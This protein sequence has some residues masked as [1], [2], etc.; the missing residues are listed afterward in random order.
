MVTIILNRCR[1]DLVFPRVIT[2]AVMLGV[3]VIFI[4][5][6]SLTLGKNSLVAVYLY[7]TNSVTTVSH[8]SERATKS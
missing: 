1:Y 2:I 3:K 7:C 4:F 5:S 8:G 6:L